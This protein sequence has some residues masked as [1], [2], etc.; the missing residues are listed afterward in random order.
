MLS[1]QLSSYIWILGDL[2]V[3]S[4]S[5]LTVDDVIIRSPQQCHIIDCLSLLLLT[6]FQHN[7]SNQGKAD[8][9]PEPHKQ[10]GLHNPGC[11]FLKLVDIIY[12]SLQLNTS[13]M[14][15]QSV[16]HNLP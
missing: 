7:M 3:G 12:P 8:S 2:F 9:I 6:F 5:V 10:N 4:S 11:L 13:A 1:K 16:S 14:P 15:P